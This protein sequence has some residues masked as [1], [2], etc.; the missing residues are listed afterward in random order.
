M[1]NLIWRHHN[2][3]DIDAFFP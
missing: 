3:L 2:A 1:K